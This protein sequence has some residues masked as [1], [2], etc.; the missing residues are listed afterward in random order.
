SGSPADRTQ[1]GRLLVAVPLL[2]GERVGGAVRADRSGA[3]AATD[4]RQAWAVLV[5]GA[6]SLIALAVLAALVLGRRLAAPLERMAAAA[7]RLGHGDFAARAPRTGVTE[8]DEVAGAL[9]STAQRLHDLIAR[10]R[11]FSADASHQLRTPLA[12]LLIELESLEL[13]GHDVRAAL[14]QV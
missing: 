12:A 5:G 13:Q 14:A 8:L 2:V 6:V 4:A 1:D 7:T 3:D 10:E 11:A 9:D